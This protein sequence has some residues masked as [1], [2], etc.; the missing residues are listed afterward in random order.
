MEALQAVLVA[1][2]LICVPSQLQ[3]ATNGANTQCTSTQTCALDQVLA[4]PF[5]ASTQNSDI[6]TPSKKRHP[7][8]QL[9]RV[10]KVNE[11][12]VGNRFDVLAR[13]DFY[14]DQ[15]HTPQFQAQQ[16]QRALQVQSVARHDPDLQCFRHAQQAQ[17][18]PQE[19]N[20]GQPLH[21][22]G[23]LRG[24]FNVNNEK[25]MRQEIEIALESMNG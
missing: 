22:R 19:Q 8:Q 10:A 21:V 25:E 20:L 23:Q 24:T 14:P 5:Q 12:N 11:S 17:Q 15:F 3:P 7:S 4:K 6:N 13:A 1:N 2:G 18:V 16:A 9:E